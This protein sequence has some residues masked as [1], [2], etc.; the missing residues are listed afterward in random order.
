[1]VEGLV[2]AVGV[3]GER[4]GEAA[5]DENVAGEAG[6]DREGRLVVV[7][8]ADTDAPF[9]A[10]AQGAAVD[11]AAVEVRAGAERSVRGPGLGCCDPDVGGV[12]AAV[13]SVGAMVVV[14]EAEQVELGLELLEGARGGLL[15]E[16][17]F[18]GLVEPFDFAVG[19]GVLG[20]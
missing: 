17:A 11:S 12:L 8:G 4:A 14:D 5:V 20:A 7:G 15:R 10:E 16:P 1:M 13:R 19:L 3:E 9:G 6:H 18:E 2:D